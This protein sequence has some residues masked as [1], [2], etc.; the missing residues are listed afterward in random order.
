MQTNALTIT[1]QQELKGKLIEHKQ[2]I[3]NYRLDL[4]R[5]RD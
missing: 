2:S 5:I 4:P 3:D 1:L